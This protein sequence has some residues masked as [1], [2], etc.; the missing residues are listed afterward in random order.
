VDLWGRLSNPVQRRL[1]DAAVDDLVRSHSDGASIDSLAR[2]LG[3]HRT[4]LLHHLDRR[5]VPRPPNTRKM[6]DRTVR[7]AATWYQTGESLK[8]V[9]ARF[10]VDPRTRAREFKKAGIQVRPRRGWSPGS[11]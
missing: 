2:R 6:T 3:V 9:A 7:Q 10:G 1:S 4:T 5:G 11:P 8:T